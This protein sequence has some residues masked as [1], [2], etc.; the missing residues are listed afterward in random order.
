MQMQAPHSKD[1]ASPY[2]DLFLTLY[3]W[4]AKSEFDGAPSTFS[5]TLYLSALNLINIIT[6]VFI[7]ESL[8][9]RFDISRAWAIAV[10]VVLFLANSAYV[11]SQSDSLRNARSWVT[12]SHRGKRVAQAYVALSIVLFVSATIAFTLTGPP[13][14]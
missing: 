2:W 12:P 9:A 7:C 14:V 11:R 5:A 4:S 3:G 13:A 1:N 6:V 8:G 10:P